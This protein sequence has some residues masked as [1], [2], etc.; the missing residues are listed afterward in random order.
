MATLSSIREALQA[1]PFEPF[2]LKLVDANAYTIRHPDFV[3]IPPVQRPREIL[4]Y[5]LG[6][7]GPGSYRTHKIDLSLV[8][9]ITIPS[10]TVGP[11][12]ASPQAP[13]R[14]APGAP[15]PTP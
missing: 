12:A 2:D 3:S 7:Y 6:D 1:H 10:A 14:P 5:T 8:C 11:T 4:V 15:P 9:E 13:G